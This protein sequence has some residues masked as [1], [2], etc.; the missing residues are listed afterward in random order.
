MA[1]VKGLQTDKGVDVMAPNVVVCTGGFLGGEDMQMQ[2]FNTPVYS[3]GNSLSDGAGINM[4]LDAGGALDRNF[5]V[6]GNECGAVSAGHH[7][8][9]LHRGLG[10]TSTSIT[11][12]GCSA[13]CTPT[14]PASASSTKAR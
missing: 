9:P 5:A 1:W 11:A 10:I 14:P 13:A 2:V 3:L 6:L 7:G 12:T 8:Q 4:V